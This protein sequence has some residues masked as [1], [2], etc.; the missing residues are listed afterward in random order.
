MDRGFYYLDFVFQCL[1]L[2]VKKILFFF[3]TKIRLL[4]KAV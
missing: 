3:N 4:D 2:L 1:F